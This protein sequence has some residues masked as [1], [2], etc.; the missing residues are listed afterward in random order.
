MPGNGLPAEASSGT[1]GS[2][3]LELNVTQ[4]PVFRR[5]KFD[6]HQDLEVDFVD[7]ILGAT[8]RSAPAGLLQGLAMQP[9]PCST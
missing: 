9:L 6:I 5:H 8:L 1:P 3:L 2:L 4:H 7:M